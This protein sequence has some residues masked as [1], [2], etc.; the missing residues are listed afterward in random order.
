MSDD[1]EITA[2]VRQRLEDADESEPDTD[3]SSDDGPLLTLDEGD[4]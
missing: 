3:S 2:D 4:D 1:T